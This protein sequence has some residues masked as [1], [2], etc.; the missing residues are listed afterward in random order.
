VK[1]ARRMCATEGYATVKNGV[2][3]HVLRS[4]F[5]GMLSVTLRSKSNHKPGNG[6]VQIHLCIVKISKFFHCDILKSRSNQKTRAI[7][8]VSLLDVTMNKYLVKIH[9]IVKLLRQIIKKQSLTSVTLK[10]G[11]TQ[12]PG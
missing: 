5:P 11:S 7:C 4:S 9:P 1:Y 12:K 3:L 8:D 6:N 10:S 2:T